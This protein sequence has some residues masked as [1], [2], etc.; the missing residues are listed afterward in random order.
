MQ[1]IRVYSKANMRMQSFSMFSH[2]ERESI[3][4]YHRLINI[5]QY[6][7]DILTFLLCETLSLSSAP[8]CAALHSH[9]TWPLPLTHTQTSA[10]P[11][12]HS[13]GCRREEEKSN[14]ERN[15]IFLTPW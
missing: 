13:H 10:A 14:G 4:A 15:C 8:V 9:S 5:G 11:L 12:S 1:L 6:V 7:T 2:T 3:I